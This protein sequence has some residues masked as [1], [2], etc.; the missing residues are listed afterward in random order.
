MLELKP[1]NYFILVHLS[2]HITTHRNEIMGT[3]IVLLIIWYY[4]NY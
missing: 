2:Y 1:L 3:I 4:I